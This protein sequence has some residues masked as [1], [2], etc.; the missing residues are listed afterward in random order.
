[1]DEWVIWYYKV[2]EGVLSWESGVR[3]GGKGGGMVGGEGGREEWEKKEE[4][5]GGR[6]AEERGKGRKGRERRIMVKHTNK[7]GIQKCKRRTGA[8]VYKMKN[9]SRHKS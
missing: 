5:R 8:Q 9:S 1:M 4:G 3:M 2:S 6:V 7:V